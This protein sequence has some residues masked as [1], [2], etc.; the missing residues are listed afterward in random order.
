VK[1]SKLKVPSE[2]QVGG[3]AWTIKEVTTDNDLETPSMFGRCRPELQTIYYLKD[4]TEDGA[5]DTVLHELI[6]ALDWHAQLKLKEKQVHVLASL[7]VECM[8]DNPELFVWLM[9]KPE[10][11]K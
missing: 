5:R 7:L 8:W 6:H 1:Q 10:K 2:I 3:K 4:C 9:I 11:E